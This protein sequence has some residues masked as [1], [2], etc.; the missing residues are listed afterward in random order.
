MIHVYFLVF[1]S[2]LSLVERHGILGNISM[3][4]SL[5][6][7]RNQIKQEEKKE[8]RK[9]TKTNQIMRYQIISL[10]SFYGCTRP[11]RT[12]C[13][14]TNNELIDTRDKFV[15][16]SVFFLR[17]FRRSRLCFT[18]VARKS[19]RRAQAEITNKRSPVRA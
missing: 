9:Q 17:Y 18:I 19:S 2:F 15:T 1:I 8:R 14:I 10:Y 11:T 12:G 7:Y 4:S 3:V 5:I 13:L 16:L 6:F